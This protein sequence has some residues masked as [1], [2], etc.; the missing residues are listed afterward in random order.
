MAGEKSYLL[1]S[2]EVSLALLN[3]S[4]PTVL[5]WL[6]GGEGGGGVGEALEGRVAGREVVSKRSRGKG[7]KR[8]EAG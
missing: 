6:G 4:K 8:P 5:P 2:W 3:L 7:S 1:G